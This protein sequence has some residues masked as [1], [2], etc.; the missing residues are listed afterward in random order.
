MIFKNVLVQRKFSI[1]SNF[2]DTTLQVEG[3]LDKYIGE[4]LETAITTAN[5]Y[6]EKIAEGLRKEAESM[7]GQ[8]V[9]ETIQG[10]KEKSPPIGPPP[11]LEINVLHER[12]QIAIENSLSIEDL[13]KVKEAYPVMPFPLLRLYSKKME[14]LSNEPNKD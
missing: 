7:R 6:L 1:Y 5:K 14:E 9:T 3:E 2:L 10:A 13:K 11:P 8:I 12:V 4:S